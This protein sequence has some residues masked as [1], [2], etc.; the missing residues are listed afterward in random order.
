MTKRFK[1]KTKARKKRKNKSSKK[2]VKKLETNQE[3]IIKTKADWVNKA[4]VN[5]SDYEKKYK[6]SLKNNDEFWKKEGKRIT[7][8]KPYKK[9]KN[10]KY[11][12]DEVHIKW[13]EDGTLNASANCIDRHLKNKKN[14]TAIIW[15]GDDPKDTKKIS[16][17]QLH[18]EVSK[19]A[20]ALKELGIRKGDRVTIYLTMIPELAITMLACA[21]IGAIHSIIFGGFSSDSIAGR[22]DDC[23]SDYV[24][25]AD[26]GI[27]GGKIIP[28]KNIVDEALI[29]CRSIKKCIVI[30]RTGNYI[31]W[32]ND[33]DIWYHDI[34]KNILMSHRS[35]NHVTTCSMKDSLR[36]SS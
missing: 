29:K 18:K 33:R 35:I 30:K 15:A 20:N 16:Y 22:I 36:F 11:S 13:Y 21:R 19:T 28:L 23:K 34:I 8:I 27:R 24:I 3:L 17:K 7:W 32:N 2:K 12:K 5:K 25:T 31:Y 26:E 4:L 6:K 1:K 14:K 9:I 10:V